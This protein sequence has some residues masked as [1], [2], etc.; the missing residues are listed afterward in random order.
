MEIETALVAAGLLGRLDRRPNDDELVEQIE[1][2]RRALRNGQPREK[3]PEDL[4]EPVLR[5]AWDASRVAR[6]LSGGA[7]PAEWKAQR[8]DCRAPLNE[9]VGCRTV[10]RRLRL[11]RSVTGA[12]SGVAARCSAAE[13]TALRSAESLDRAVAIVTVS[14]LTTAATRQ[15]RASISTVVRLLYHPETRSIIALYQSS[16]LRRARS[17]SP[18]ASSMSVKI[19]VRSSGLG[20]CVAT[21]SRI[22]FR[23][24]VTPATVTRSSGLPA[25]ALAVVAM[26]HRASANVCEGMYEGSLSGPL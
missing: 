14:A 1:P 13:T 2:E 16:M 5:T 24:F 10:A 20:T 26:F 25:G 11:Y 4:E 19:A 8:I 12:R 18:L 7:D 23:S 6:I 9:T 15:P 17:R 3:D 22:C 21:T